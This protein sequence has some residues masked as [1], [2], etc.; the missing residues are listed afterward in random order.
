MAW[1]GSWENAKETVEPGAQGVKRAKQLFL[2]P[3]NAD[4]SLYF[5]FVPR[6]VGKPK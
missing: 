6:W 2:S 4:I 1:S 3:E 5:F